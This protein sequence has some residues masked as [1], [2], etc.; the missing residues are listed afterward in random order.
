MMAY[1]RPRFLYESELGATELF[2]FLFEASGS[3][4]L[5]AKDPFYI[6]LIARMLCAWRRQ[7]GVKATFS[8]N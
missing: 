5:S 7:L 3:G 6:Q 8:T 2:H 1:Q 4:E